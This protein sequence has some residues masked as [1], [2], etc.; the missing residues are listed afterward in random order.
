MF[1]RRSLQFSSLIL[2]STLLIAACAA[3]VPNTNPKPGNTAP[4]KQD[5]STGVLDGQ[6]HN[7]SN[8]VDNANPD[9]SARGGKTL[10]AIYLLGSDLESG[11]EA[12]STDLNEMVQAYEALTPDERQNVDL[13]I[14]F[15]GA[16]KQGWKGIKYADWNCVVKD[17]QDQAYGNDT[18]YSQ[19]KDSVNMGKSQTLSD[20][21][22]YVNQE[23]PAA[24]YGKRILDL[25]DHGGAHDGFGP[26]ENFDDGVMSL[27]AI[28][29]ALKVNTKK[30]DMIGFDACLMAN[31]TVARHVH[32]HAHYLLAS[33]ELEPGHGWQYQDVLTYIGKNP[34]SSV[35]DIGKKMVDSFVSHPEHLAQAGKTLSL[36]N[37]DVF[38]Q[39]AQALDT[40]GNQLSLNQSASYGALL[41][42]S[43]RSQGYGKSANG[44]A[45]TSVDTHHFVKNLKTYVPNINTTAL[46]SALKSYAMYSR[47]DGTR[48]DSNGA[49]MFPIHNSKHYDQSRYNQNVAESDGWFQFVKGFLSS[50]LADS[51]SPQLQQAPVDTAQSLNLEADLEALFDSFFTFS[52]QQSEAPCADGYCYQAQDNLGLEAVYSVRGSLTDDQKIQLLSSTPALEIAEGVFRSPDWDGK[53]MHLCATED[54]DGQKIIVPLEY[55]D[56]TEDGTFLF[57]ADGQIN[58][59]DVTFYVEM[60]ARREFVDAWAVPFEFEDGSQETGLISREQIELA[61]GDEIAFYLIEIDAETEDLSLNLSKPI[62]LTEDVDLQFLRP[63][64][65]LFSLVIAE[66][67]KGNFEVSE[68]QPFDK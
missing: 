53:V 40:L 42:A 25:W 60:N 52:I 55:D 15:G 27:S 32:P 20:F 57:I 49:A 45:P 34:Q 11:S 65:N 38:P 50:G 3:Q 51:V 6:Q 58:G 39:V 19:A 46:E 16:N 35:V 10:F 56:R 12:G 59:Q 8:A 23:Y 29:Q 28:N 48:P 44:D 4:I 1:I 2:A 61:E 33:E 43:T 26:D 67:L 62:T 22:N 36:V 21:V 18:C 9:Q 13:V 64:G 24:N 14:G 30:F 7:A 68:A 41:D 47:D 63:D 5:G 66:D 54:C 17:G 31:L 37:L